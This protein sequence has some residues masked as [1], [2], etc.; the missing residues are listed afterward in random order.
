MKYSCDESMDAAADKFS[1][2][3][4]KA[5]ASN[6]FLYGM[7]CVDLSFQNASLHL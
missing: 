7:R 3:L 4:A 6:L 2:A 5:N 1:M